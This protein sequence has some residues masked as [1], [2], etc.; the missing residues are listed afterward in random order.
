LQ[1]SVRDPKLQLEDMKVKLH[2]VMRLRERIIAILEQFGR[3]LLVGTLRM[4][5][6]DIEAE[7][8]RRIRELPDGT[9]RVV[10]FMDSTLR[11]TAMQK[12]GL[13]IT[14]KGERMTLDFRGTAPQFL[15]RAV[16]TNLASF[17]AALCT[18]LL[19]NIWPDLPH[20]M[21]VLSPIE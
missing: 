1:N 11:E 2:A 10:Q 7:M 21:A 18:G 8:R 4:H 17:K 16:N 14:V 9:V 5:L 19:Q 20:S 15:N 6:E 13:A 12:F 3:D